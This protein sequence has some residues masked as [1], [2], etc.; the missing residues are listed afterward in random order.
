MLL[1]EGK[2]TTLLLREKRRLGTGEGQRS[3]IAI[4]GE[5]C[6]HSY[7]GR[8]T[9]AQLLGEERFFSSA[10]GGGEN[11]RQCYWGRREAVTL[12]LAEEISFGS[13]IGGGAKFRHCYWGEERSS[14]TA[15]WGRS[16]A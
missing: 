8:S 1:V 10:I 14:G 16:N 12:L 6:R 9:S 3:G 11:L 13:A 4:V 7:W 2:V 5:K 15:I